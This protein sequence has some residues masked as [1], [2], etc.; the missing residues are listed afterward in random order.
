MA[1]ILSFTAEEVW[2]H[3]PRTAARPDSILLSPL[4]EPDES[5]SDA[6]LAAEWDL[7]L[8]LRGEV[9][10]A[11][12]AARQCGA[13]GHSLDARV[14]LYPDAYGNAPEIQEL[15][16]AGAP[17][18][19]EDIFI[20]SQ[21]SVTPGEPAGDLV[22]ADLKAGGGADEDGSAGVA[23]APGQGMGYE[24]VL[25]GGAIG[26]Y[27]ADGG[28]C[29]RCWKYHAAVGADAAHPGVCPRCAEV[30]RSLP[31]AESAHA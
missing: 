19:W 6:A 10:K 13:I 16:R 30:L 31:Q 18:P 22:H 8:S 2:E 9:L 7:R 5:L 25:L 20:V 1:P 21:V 27:P 26:V 14:V 24:S 28:K 11:L 23:P 29:E 17:M 3:A 15:L 12:E 4:P